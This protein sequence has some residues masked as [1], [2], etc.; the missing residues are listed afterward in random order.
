MGSM[1]ARSSTSSVSPAPLDPRL[2]ATLSRGDAAKYR[3]CRGSIPKRMYRETDDRLNAWVISARLAILRPLQLPRVLW[4]RVLPMPLP[5]YAGKMKR[6]ARNHKDPRRKL[7]EYPTIV[8][9]SSANQN[10]AGSF[11]SQNA[12]WGSGGEVEVGSS[13]KPC[14]LLRSSMAIVKTVAVS[15]ISSVLD[16]LY[17]LSS[18]RSSHEREQN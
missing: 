12:Y 6:S 14:F 18:D 10:E 8:W 4:M 7:N 11:L 3:G 16:L 2:F 13:K 1:F 9:P 17:T 5:W 15:G